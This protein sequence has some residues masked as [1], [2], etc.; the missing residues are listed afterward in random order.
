MIEKARIFLANN[1]AYLWIILLVIF[2]IYL[3]LNF[4]SKESLRLDESQSIWQSNRSIYGIF[5]TLA[6]D[7]HVP[8]YPVML[9]F[10]R[11]AFGEMIEIERNLSLLF[12][13]LSIPAAYAVS[14]F[15]TKSKQIGLYVA[16]LFSIS[17]FLNWYGN[18]LR[19]YSL[20][21]LIVL[22]S[23][24]LFLK[25]YL[26]KKANWQIWLG[27]IVIS[28]VGIYTHYFY[29]FIILCQ[30]IFFLLYRRNFAKN[31]IY[32]FLAHAL[33]V[34]V[35]FLPWVI[36]VKKIDSASSSAPLLFRPTSIDIINIYSQHFFGFQSDN[37]NS[38]L[39][40]LW[41]LLTIFC[42]YLLK[43]QTVIDPKYVYLFITTFL[44]TILAIIISLTLRPVLLSRYLIIT[45]PSLFILV[46]ILLFA[47]RTFASSVAQVVFLIVVF[48]GLVKEISNPNIA[49]KENYREAIA[50]I[51]KEAKT[52]DIVTLSAPF[53]VYPFDYYYNSS[54]TIESIPMWNRQTGIPPYNEELMKN[55]IADYKTKYKKLY[56]LLS[57]DQGYEKSI[58][59]YLDTNFLQLEKKNYSPKLNLFVYEL[60]N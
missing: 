1:K 23:H 55:Q 21:V 31:S 56:I 44:P 60:N 7:V 5:E 25:V 16:T 19:M 17:P 11:K 39:I 30:Y 33:F 10:W 45:L 52:T 6:R 26:A 47:K 2:N 46:S 4:F 24:Y 42:L 28:L 58:K 35:T 8:L 41:P 43:K 36:F 38:L 29:F 57:Y 50:Y 54:T 14:K 34:F 51:N 9:H 37:L 40:S 20:L 32:G 49:V 59:D 18:E 48:T 12:Y 53:T 15:L 13:L 3:S 22:S 27:Y